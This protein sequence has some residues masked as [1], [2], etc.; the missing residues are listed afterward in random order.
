VTL[1]HRV[2]SESNCER[3]SSARKGRDLF[4][5][6]AALKTSGDPCRTVNRE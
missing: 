6:W 5:L 1:R 4:D 2:D 3:S